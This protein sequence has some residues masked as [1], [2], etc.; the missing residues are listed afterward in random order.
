M[1]GG[2]V[3]VGVGEGPTEV[4]G[5]DGVTWCHRKVKI[6]VK[7]YTWT[8]PLTQK[9]LEQKVGNRPVPFNTR[10]ITPVH[11]LLPYTP[12]EGRIRGPF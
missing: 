11:T 8:L 3:T 4:C 10:K 1:S 5:V 6:L 12:N 9:S 7:G 2:E